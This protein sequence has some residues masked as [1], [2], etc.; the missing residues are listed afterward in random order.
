MQQI[1]HYDIAALFVNSIIILL[2]FRRNNIPALQNRIFFALLIDCFFTVLFETLSVFFIE[3]PELVPRAIIWIVNCLYFTFLYLFSLIACSYSISVVEYF[4]IARR[5]QLISLNYYLF[6]PV[7]I[8][9]IFVWMSPL[10]DFTNQKLLGVF[11][12][13]E[14]NIYQRGSVFFLNGYV[15]SVYYAVLSI[16]F[17]IKYKK[18]LRTSSANRMIA[19]FA[20]CYS[21]AVIQFLLPNVLIQCFVIS[22]AILLFEITIRHPEDIIDVN[23]GLFNQLAFVSSNSK[24][25]RHQRCSCIGL[26]LDDV[27]FISNTFGINQFNKLLK[28]VSDTLV[29]EFSS[30]SIYYLGQGQFIFVFKKTTKWDIQKLIG[31]LQNIFTKPWKSDSI[32]IKLYMKL[33][34]IQCPDDAASPEDVIDLISITTDS[35]RYGTAVVYASEINI[36]HKRRTSYIEYSLR[37]GLFENRFEVYYQ[38]IYSTKKKK[39]IGAEALIRLRDEEGQFISPEVFIPIAEKTGTILRIGEFVFESVCKTLSEIDLESCGIEKID[40]NLSVAQCMQEILADQLLTIISMYKLPKSIINMEITETAMAHTPEVLLQ[41]IEKL[42][43]AGIEFSLDDYG[44]GYS[45]MNYML[46]LPFSMIKIDKGIVWSA[47]SDKRACLALKSTIKMISELGMSVLAEGVETKEQSDWLTELGCD[48]L[49]G[50]YFAKPMPKK[51]FIEL[52][53]KE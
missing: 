35:E 17:L 1:I 53:K 16:G 44:S 15:M 36:E 7:V 39:L 47:F 30:A 8:S 11:Y 41:N 4:D 31:K 46:T 12:L 42:V 52:M 22:L 26:V 21:G 49:Q 51:D 2:F 18:N 10:Y 6:I 29:K 38:P 32:T 9:V 3:N 50:F 28:I 19:F 23:T 25:K 40:V 20:L 34:I 43:E 24:F 33:C 45:N 27:S 5:R 14:N 48:Y 37:S 13:D